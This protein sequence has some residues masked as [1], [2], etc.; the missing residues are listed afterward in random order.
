M[1]PRADPAVQDWL[2]RQSADTL[3]LTATSLAELLAGV[4][5]LP[6]GKRRAGL[7][8]ALSDLIARLFGPRLLPFDRPA[9]QDFAVVVSRARSSGYAIGMADGQIAAIAAVHGFAVATRDAAPF[10]AAGVPVINPW[11]A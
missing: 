6:E 1:R 7:A 4:E 8:A 5:V 2:D 11:A 9:A 10:K 3:Y